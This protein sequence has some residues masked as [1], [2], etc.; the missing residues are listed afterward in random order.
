MLFI[1]LQFYLQVW[2]ETLTDCRERS[3][4]NRF[5]VGRSVKAGLNEGETRGVKTGRGDEQGWCLSPILF[6]LHN[7][8]LTKLWKS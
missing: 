6:N 4:V 3:L 8:C 5:N 2:K 7:A 1:I